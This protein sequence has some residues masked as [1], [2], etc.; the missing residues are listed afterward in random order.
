LYEFLSYNVEDKS[1]EYDHY[2]YWE[3][4]GTILLDELMEILDKKI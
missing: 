1:V 3:E 2:D 4:G